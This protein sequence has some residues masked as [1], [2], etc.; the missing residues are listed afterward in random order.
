MAAVR[1]LSCVLPQMIGQMLLTGERLG[2][3]LTAMRRFACVD[4]HVV[5]QVLLASER[6]G[7]KLTAVR[8]LTSMLTNMIIQMLFPC[9]GLCAVPEIQHENQLVIGNDFLTLNIQSASGKIKSVIGLIL[10][11][12]EKEVGGSQSEVSN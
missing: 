7:A 12:R 10:S 2:A 11:N 3:E 4:P 8:R 5:S 6:L 9:E 1:S